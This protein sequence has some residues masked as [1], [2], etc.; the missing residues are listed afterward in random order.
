MRAYQIT[1]YSG[2]AMP[3]PSYKN[4]YWYPD[5][6]TDSTDPFV[7]LNNERPYRFFD[8]N[9]AV[10]KYTFTPTSPIYVIG[11]SDT[12]F[13]LDVPTS[14]SFP[15][16]PCYMAIRTTAVG[17]SARYRYAFIMTRGT[18]DEKKVRYT[19]R[20]DLWTERFPELI[21]EQ[22][23]IS[24]RHQ[25]RYVDRT[26]ATKVK[27]YNGLSDPI[28]ESMVQGRKIVQAIDGLYSSKWSSGGTYLGHIIPIWVYWRLKTN[29]WY[30][31]SGDAWIKRNVD[32]EGVDPTKSALPVIARCVGV[33]VVKNNDPTSCTYYPID[34]VLNSSGTQMTGYMGDKQ[35]ETFA[36]SNPYI[37]QAFVSTIPPFKCSYPKATTNF[38]V[39][40]ED[41]FFD[42]CLI[43]DNTTNTPTR[44]GT[45][46]D[47]ALVPVQGTFV[48]FYGSPNHSRVPSG[49]SEYATLTTNETTTFDDGYEPKI[50][51]SPY[52]NVTF[53]AFGADLDI[54]PNPAN[55]KIRVRITKGAHRDLIFLSGNDEIHRMSGIA[56]SKTIDA[57]I[58]TIDQ[59]LV[60]AAQTHNNAEVWKGWNN[61]INTGSRMFQG[62]MSGRTISAVAPM[63]TGMLGFMQQ[64]ET[65]AAFQKDMRNSPNSAN[66]ASESAVDNFPY[67]DLP[68]LRKR[69]LPDGIKQKIMRFWHVYGYPDNRS[70]TIRNSITRESFVYIQ[71]TPHAPVRG[72]LPG[73]QT[74]FQTAIASGIWFNRIKTQT[75]HH[76]EDFGYYYSEIGENKAT[77]TNSEVET[78]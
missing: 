67:L 1:F 78:E 68:I 9:P 7:G 53:D 34:Y 33:F 43:Y 37:A 10:S 49:T 66:V 3:D 24:R 5:V 36:F 40:I 59:W 25:D 8:Q 77:T 45:G 17:A 48:G 2:S 15:S 57:M 28:P 32:L 75:V 44:I 50:E 47:G 13:V 56:P 61:L 27:L 6:G 46:D 41:S 73:Q 51:E 38:N 62:A 54:S 19:C 74:D 65:E 12:S 69:V 60:T 55:P 70:D 11:N 4:V 39:K 14:G 63:A 23:S 76:G 72:L 21:D 58:E 22:Y 64:V 18:L 52:E 42:T 71:A 20:F 31:K 29:V 16:D 26:A 35:I 30:T